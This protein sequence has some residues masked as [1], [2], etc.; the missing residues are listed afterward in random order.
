VATSTEYSEPGLVQLG[1]GTVIC[2]IRDDD[3]E[4]P[5][6]IRQSTSADNGATW[7]A[8]TYVTDGY[9]PMNP[10]LLESGAIIGPL[11]YA[12][13]YDASAPPCLLYSGDSGSSWQIGHEFERSPNLATPGAQMYGQFDQDGD[14]TIYAVYGDE[15]DDESASDVMFT[16]ALRGNT[17]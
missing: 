9:G 7:A 14:G 11:R 17:T 1:G 6:T 3:P 15:E 8:E 5:R 2:L 13:Y 12:N 16:K 10:S 4:T